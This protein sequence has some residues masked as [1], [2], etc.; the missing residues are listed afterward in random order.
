MMTWG[1]K[2]L[3]IGGGV[4]LVFDLETFYATG[5]NYQQRIDVG[6]RIHCNGRWTE[7]LLIDK[8]S[9]VWWC[10]SIKYYISG[11]KNY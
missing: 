3:I 5:E 9:S 11:L 6:K 10:C 1:D 7:L 8:D 2:W 4:D